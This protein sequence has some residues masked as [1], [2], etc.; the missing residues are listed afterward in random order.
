MNLATSGRAR[1]AATTV[2]VTGTLADGVTF[3]GQLSHVSA[4]VIN[5]E[6]VLFATL[7]GPD[8]PDDGARL[9]APVEQLT[10]TRGC[11]VL[12]VAVGHPHLNKTGSVI[13]L[14]T[15]DFDVSSVSGSGDLRGNPLCAGWPDGAGSLQDTAA[16]FNRLVNGLRP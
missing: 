10:A 12:S 16:L 7:V 15:I 2:N 6:L 5:G 13:R 4:S 14:G 3:V 11:T 1:P 8:L 9:T